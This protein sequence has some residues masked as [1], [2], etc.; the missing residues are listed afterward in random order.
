MLPASMIFS[1]EDNWRCTHKGF[2]NR[3]RKLTLLLVDQI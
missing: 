1:G 2:L 3:G